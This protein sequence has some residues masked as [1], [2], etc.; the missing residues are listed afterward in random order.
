MDFSNAGCLPQKAGAASRLSR[1]ISL[2]VLASV[3]QACSAVKIIYDR[4]PDLAYWYLDG[5]LDFTDAQSLQVK[6][7]LVKLQAWHRKTQLPDYIDALQ[8]LQ[9]Q[10]SSEMDGAQVCAIFSELRRKLITVSGQAEAAALALAGTLEARQ[11]TQLERKFSA[12]NADYKANFLEGRPQSRRDKRYKRAVER[13]EML[14]GRLGEEQL[15]LVGKA[16]D[17][18]GFDAAVIYAERLRRQRDA[19]ESLRTLLQNR[20]SQTLAPAQAQSI[21]R[22]LF[23]RTINSPDNRYRIYIEKFTQHSCT[24]FASLHNSTTA[25]QRTKARKTLNA[26][27]QDLRALTG[28]DGF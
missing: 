28:A 4:A 6:D 26:H 9:L 27:E 10:M 17:E 16:I 22:G 13:A 18:S 11:L 2:L 5:Y 7:E 15:V 3:L 25:T 21:M 8:K 12:E 14:Y 19:S 1:I 20:S 23:E 24:A